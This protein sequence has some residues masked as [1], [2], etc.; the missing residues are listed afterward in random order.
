MKNGQ[1]LVIFY[2]N[3]DIRRNIKKDTTIEKEKPI[4]KR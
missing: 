2:I 4:K 3:I 1:E